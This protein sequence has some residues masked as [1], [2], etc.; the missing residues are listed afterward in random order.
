[1][2][3]RDSA[4][5]ARGPSGGD[6][7]R[8]FHPCLRRVDLQQ[9]MMQAPRK[10]G[11]RRNGG[12]AGRR[13]GRTPMRRSTR[14]LALAALF[15]LPVAGLAQTIGGSVTGRVLAEA[16]QPLSGSTVVARNLATGVTRTAV[17]DASG[18]YRL[19]ELTAGNYEFTVEMKGFATEVRSGVKISIGQRA[20]LDFSLKV[21]AVAE[22]V[23]VVGE[24]PLV[25]TTKSSIGAS[26]SRQQIDQLPLPERDFE[27]LAFLAPGISPS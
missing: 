6:G 17:T 25:E 18:N 9:R 20:T 27:S 15:L 3:I 11:G 24:A 23:T 13:E 12:R 2:C 21:S 10:F 19:A 7:R 4:I 16:G 14:A 22:T 26:V 5:G 1:M 8:A